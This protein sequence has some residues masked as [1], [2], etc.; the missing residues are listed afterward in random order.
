[1]D[2]PRLYCVQD[3]LS[4][5][6]FPPFCSPNDAVAERQFVDL[7]NSPESVL[8]KHPDHYRLYMV[9]RFDPDL[10]VVMPAQ[11]IVCVNQGLTVPGKRQDVA[12]A[13]ESAREKFQAWLSARGLDGPP[14]LERSK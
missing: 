3:I 12:L 5:Q 6:Y 2:I 13:E 9:G 10:G 4:Q 7:L 8:S 11:E 14:L 1:M